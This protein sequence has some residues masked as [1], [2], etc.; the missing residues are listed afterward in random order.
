MQWTSW[1]KA[2]EEGDLALIPHTLQPDVPW[3]GCSTMMLIFLLLV[4]SALDILEMWHN[5]FS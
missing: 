2:G 1:P 4:F 5:S 3:Y